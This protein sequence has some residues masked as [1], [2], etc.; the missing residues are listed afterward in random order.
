MRVELIVGLGNPGPEYADT[1]HNIGFLCLDELARRHGLGFGPLR[2]A[3][4]AAAG[5]VQGRPV[6]LIKP[7]AYM[8]RS[9]EALAGWA[10]AEGLALTGAPPPPPDEDGFPV[11][12]TGSGRRP[13]I[14]VDDIALPL[15]AV[16]LRARGS[17]GG[18]NGLASLDRCLGGEHYPRLRLGVGGEEPVPPAAWADYVLEAFPASD[19]AAV[20]ELVRAGADALELVLALGVDGAASRCNRRRPP[21]PS[22]DEDLPS[23]PR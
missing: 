12:E 17:A 4:Q 15:G 9:G 19:A 14:V 3:C 16:R 7:L 10:R 11:P 18:H 20:A 21:R 1:R 2:H 23:P 8:N 6:T 22:A 5:T 13:L